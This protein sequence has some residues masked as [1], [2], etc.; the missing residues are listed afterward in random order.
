[1]KNSTAYI[2]ALSLGYFVLAKAPNS[3]ALSSAG[4]IAQAPKQSQQPARPALGKKARKP[5]IVKGVCDANVAGS[6]TA[7]VP[8]SGVDILTSESLNLLFFV[9]DSG[10]SGLAGI[11]RVQYNR[12]NLIPEQEISISGT[13][14]VVQV[15]VPAIANFPKAE[16]VKWSFE[17]VCK[18]GQFQTVYGWV[19]LKAPDSILTKK[20]E[21]S[22]NDDRK[23]ALVY[24]QA[25]YFLDAA[26]LLAPLVD[27]DSKAKQDWVDLLKQLNL[28]EL[29]DKTV[30]KK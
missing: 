2:F 28:H 30:V 9:P 23:K 12:K 21:E 6:L 29:T 4:D 5:L 24:R 13:P 26:A 14:G 17:V 18:N 8:E 10:S 22:K 15:A 3:E 11:L 16:P 25:G 20:L 19:N 1:M 27:Q 7:I